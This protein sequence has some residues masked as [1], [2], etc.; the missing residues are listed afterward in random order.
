MNYLDIIEYGLK[1]YDDITV[2]IIENERKK[3]SVK[4]GEIEDYNIDKSRDHFI[5]LLKDGKHYAFRVSEGSFNDIKNML[6][7]VK[8]VFVYLPKDNYQLLCSDD[9]YENQLYLKDNS[10][11]QFSTN[12]LLNTAL[13]I[14]ANALNYSDFIKKVRFTSFS[15]N[16]EKRH[17][18]FSNGEVLLEETT[19]FSGS[20]Y[21]VA[22]DGN[23]SQ[24]GYDFLSTV[25]YDDFDYNMV[26][27]RAARE[28][29]DLLGSKKLKS[30][31]YYIVFKNSVMAEFLDL[32]AELVNAENI[33]KNKSFLKNKIGENITSKII[34]L[35]DDSKMEG[36]VGSYYFDDE[37]VAG[38]KT[39]IFKDGLLQGYLHN[40]YTS[41]KLNHKN[42]GNASISGSGKLGISPSNLIL[43]GENIVSFDEIGKFDNVLF[44]TEVMGMHMADPISGN[45]SIGINGTYYKNGE[46]ITPFG[47]LVLTGNLADLLYNVI[48]IFDD[49]RDFGGVITPSVMF[50][51]FTVSGS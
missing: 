34:N 40:S 26:G 14:E 21:V 36:C 28:A 41:K 47:E 24:S 31:K 20:T 1:L 37:G 27:Q 13:E 15:A 43:T 25:F 16:L 33:L 18:I 46:K 39:E 30:G 9:K 19:S 6:N 5:R 35:Y 50:D 8:D 11:E 3:V 45:F 17:I 38:G 4:Q 42:T 2:L 51:K 7:E 23:D 48:A 49:A 32:I 29:V 10:Y 22:E 44:V 12:L